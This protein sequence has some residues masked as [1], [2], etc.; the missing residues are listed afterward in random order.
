MECFLKTVKVFMK[1]LE[2]NPLLKSVAWDAIHI[3]AKE[4]ETLKSLQ[5]SRRVN[6]EW[7]KNSMG[8]Q[9]P[10][11]RLQ[12]WEK[13]G[14]HG[15]E[16]YLVNT[17]K[18]VKMSVA[19]KYCQLDI[20]QKFRLRLSYAVNW[21]ET[22]IEKWHWKMQS[23]CT[24]YFFIFFWLCDRKGCGRQE[25]WTWMQEICTAPGLGFSSCLS[26]FFQHHGK[27]KVIFKTVAFIFNLMDYSQ[28][29]AHIS[30]R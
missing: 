19:W 26:H 15:N 4:W 16:N 1:L 27:I 28:C 22:Q 6:F 30:H 24:K 10:W 9:M 5:L 29:G 8:L 11:H 13:V 23:E 25:V 18:D 3:S 17:L 2:N 20:H 12:S 14:R 7:D 21:V